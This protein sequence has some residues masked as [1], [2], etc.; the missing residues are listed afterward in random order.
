MQDGTPRQ[1][2][3]RA[4]TITGEER[5]G[6]TLQPTALVNEVY[7]RLVNQRR[8]DWRK[9]YKIIENAGHVPA[10]I[11]VIREVLDWLDRYFGPIARR[12]QQTP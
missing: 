9:Q 2:P 4:Y 12:G 6:H 5:R 7:L 1:R 11:E 8:I 3:Y 10:R